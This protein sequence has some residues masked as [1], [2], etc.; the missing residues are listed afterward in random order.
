MKWL[1]IKTMRIG[2]KG[3]LVL[4][5]L[6]SPLNI[7]AQNRHK[8][9]LKTYQSNWQK[10]IPRYQKLQYA[11][12]MG[13]I[14]VGIGWDYGKKKQ[15]ETDFFIG[16]L[17]KFDDDE[18]HLTMTFKQN[19][20]PWQL[21]IDKK[22][23]EFHPFTVS[24]YI[25]KIFGEDFWTKE[26]NKYPDGYYGLATNLRVN[27]AFGQRVCLKVK[28]VSLSD[29]LTFFYEVGTNDLYLISMFTNKYLRITDIFNLSL[30]VKFQFI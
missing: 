3:V 19:Y 26:P 11:G 13:V 27:L 1:I 9:I 25:N 5:C 16:Y 7:S 4:I 28:P 18:G 17:P 23:W 8:D 6:Y 21:P 29:K 24:M 14:S 12:S 20:I 15:W 22:R 2:W 30:G 10:L